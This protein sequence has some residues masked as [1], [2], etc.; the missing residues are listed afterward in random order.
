MPGEHG[1][2]ST[3][4]LLTSG[5]VVEDRWLYGLV[6]L[7]PGAMTLARFELDRAVTSVSESSVMMSPC[8]FDGTVVQ[9]YNSLGEHI[10]TLPLTSRG[11]LAPSQ[12]DALPLQPLWAVTGDCVKR[13]R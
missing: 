2:F 13:V 12:M 1:D 4:H 3:T 9:V 7:S 10:A 8:D 5:I 11:T 6:Y